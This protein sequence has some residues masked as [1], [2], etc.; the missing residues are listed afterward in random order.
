MYVSAQVSI[1]RD[2]PKAIEVAYTRTPG[3]DPTVRGIQ[4]EA[5]EG[6][7]PRECA[8]ILYQGWARLQGNLCI[9]PGCTYAPK[10]WGR[11]DSHEIAPKC[12]GPECERPPLVK[13][14]CQAHYVQTRTGGV[15]APLRP[16]STGPTVGLTLRIPVSTLALLGPTPGPKILEIITEYLTPQKGSPTTLAPYR[17]KG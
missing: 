6:A 14:Y 11:C 15:M 4:L 17:S 1:L 10:L 9:V 2:G 12:A 3:P 16:R 5:P 7:T 8:L 13:G